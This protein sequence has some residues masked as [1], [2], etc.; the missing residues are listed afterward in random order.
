MK[1]LLALLM[2]LSISWLPRLKASSLVPLADFTG[3]NTT[4]QLSTLAARCEFIQVISDPGNANPIRFG[5]GSTISSTFGL[6]IAPGAAYNTPV[7]GQPYVLSS[8]YI[9]IATGDIAYVA[10]SN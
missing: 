8:F 5:T 4:V 3:G 2:V 1:K 9:Y 10:Y 6:R 7:T